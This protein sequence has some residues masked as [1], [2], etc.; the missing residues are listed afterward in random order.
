MLFRAVR[1]WSVVLL[2]LGVLAAGLSL[3]HAGA[4]SNGQAA[5]LVLGHPTFTESGQVVARRLRLPSSVAVDPTTGAVFVADSA[6]NRVLRF[7]SQT[8]LANGAPADGV[9]GQ[10]SFTSNTHA[11]SAQGMYYPAGVAVDASGRLWV[12][13][14]D[15]HR[16]LRFDAAASKPNGAPA[17]GVL[18]QSSFSG[19]TSAVG[20]QRMNS[21]AGVA[22]DGS[23]RL[24]V[25]DQNNHRVLRFDNAAAKPDGAAANGVFGQGG[26]ASSTFATSAQGMY[27][28]RDVVLDGSG[29]L[30]VAGQF[31][32]RV[33]RFD[34]AAAKP[35][36]AFANGV[37][38][39]PNFTSRTEATSAQGMIWAYAVAV[40][41]GGRLW[42]ADASNNRVLRFDS[43]AS[44]PNGAAADGVLGQG[45][46]TSGAEATSA[47]GMRQPADVALDGSGRLWVVDQNNQRVLRFD[48][49][50]AKPAG[51]GADGVLG[52]THFTTTR[53]VSAEE[54]YDPQAVAVDPA[55][56]KVFVADAS[57]NRVL[58][59]A[60]RASLSNGAAA[61]G[62][63]GQPDFTSN[64]EAAGAQGMDYPTSVA[65]DGAGRLWVVDSD[66][67]R[68][69]R[70][71]SAAAKPNGAAADGVLGQAGFSSNTGAAGAQGMDYPTGLATDADG[72]LWVVDSNNHR[73]LR[74]DN[75]AA[76]PNGGAADGVLGQPNF[77]SH[78]PFGGSG[79]VMDSPYG[80]AVD[81]GGRL[82]V[83][84]S[85]NHR[86][87]RFDGAAAKPDGAAADGVLGQPDFIGNTA[88]T[89]VQG[90][91]WP[92]GLAVEG[93][94]WVWVADTFNNRV[95]GFDVSDP[96][97]STPTATATP[98]ATSTPVT[99]VTATAT[100]TVTPPALRPR[101]YI[102]IIRLARR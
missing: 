101:V 84:D 100:A 67:H 55:S 60:S 86:V 40:D 23:G 27:F 96:S 102:S 72:R 58:R 48:N 85:N 20:A 64:A 37:L 73:V 95:L 87:L 3:P 54:L 36:G 98:T 41:G 39:Q 71:D 97:A 22:V 70:F 82:W 33:L 35:N 32:H 12:A 66:N 80:V 63:L 5:S 52:S 31:N 44:K 77:T 17:D 11:T 76:K 46:F 69:L 38:G 9:L 10:S 14:Q 21:P 91:Y 6:N 7:D 83:V 93:S 1:W 89:T 4:F 19:G 74:F 65:V 68:V 90:L 28:P 13:D 56:G 34:N 79:A 49:A 29:R 99:T 45:T 43:A 75:A 57:N 53:P 24:W 59:F 42:V 2:V 61:E 26:F 15:N 81:V 94:G 8:A 25:A 62:V 88:A 30:W 78:E 51:A 92:S 50:A 47:E 16:V 18:G